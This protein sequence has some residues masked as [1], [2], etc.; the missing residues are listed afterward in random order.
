MYNSAYMKKLLEFSPVNDP[1]E[2]RR[3]DYLKRH[4]NNQDHGTANSR[5]GHE[6]LAK[7]ERQ[8]RKFH[9]FAGHVVESINAE[10]SDRTHDF[11]NHREHNPNILYDDGEYQ[12]DGGDYRIHESELSNAQRFHLEDI[13]ADRFYSKLG[14]NFKNPTESRKHGADVFDESWYL[15]FSPG[16]TEKIDWDFEAE[17]EPDAKAEQSSFDGGFELGY[18]DEGEDDDDAVDEDTPR[19][20][21]GLE[22]EWIDA[23]LALYKPLRQRARRDIIEKQYQGTTEDDLPDYVDGFSVKN[24]P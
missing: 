1:K 13:R 7:E 9:R 15:T 4:A 18:D 11:K 17:P 24:R 5:H 20:Q 10:D 8:N 2:R 21:L 19:Y 16:G 23:A 3:E 14:N 22:D 6:Q 12:P